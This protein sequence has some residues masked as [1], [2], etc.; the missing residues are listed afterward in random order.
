MQNISELTQLIKTN[1]TAEV[2]KKINDAFVRMP[3]DTDFSQYNELA[4]ILIAIINTPISSNYN[5]EKNKEAIALM[6]TLWQAI[7]Q[8]DQM[9]QNDLLNNIICL[10]DS[11]K[12]GEETKILFTRLLRLIATAKQEVLDALASDTTYMNRFVNSLIDT[13]SDQLKIHT[14]DLIA[15]LI[16]YISYSKIAA[17]SATDS[18]LKEINNTLKVNKNTLLQSY[19]I[20]TIAALAKMNSVEQNTNLMHESNLLYCLRSKLINPVVD[21]AQMTK[22]V[23]FAAKNLADKNTALTKYMTVNSNVLLNLRKMVSKTDENQEILLTLL[24]TLSNESKQI[25]H[26]WP[27]LSTL[28][29]IMEKNTHAGTRYKAAEL[30]ALLLLKGEVVPFAQRKSLFDKIAT[31]LDKPDITI[32]FKTKLADI[33]QITAKKLSDNKI[34]NQT[35]EEN[36]KKHGL[37]DNSLSNSKKAKLEESDAEVVKRI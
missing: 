29:I 24:I 14:Y 9:Y 35:S 31:M 11:D 28:L 15:T 27:L 17:L 13:K 21:H 33:Q 10:M 22:T 12:V 2:I 30:F 8:N 18:L 25:I 5:D 36:T 26:Q 4:Q 6:I 19:A 37:F 3:M 20:Y 7:R 32:E 34:N 16:A 1:P 23:V